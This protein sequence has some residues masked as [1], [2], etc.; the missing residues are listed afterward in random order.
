MFSVLSSNKLSDGAKEFE[1]F[2]SYFLRVFYSGVTALYC[3]LYH[4]A[5]V[6]HL[7]LINDNFLSDN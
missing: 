7:S 6:N 2:T 3:A 4:Y 1:W 5:T